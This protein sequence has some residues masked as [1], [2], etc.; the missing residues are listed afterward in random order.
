VSRRLALKLKR[1]FPKLQF[2]YKVTNEPKVS[3]K[4]TLRQ[5]LIKLHATREWIRSRLCE[6][7]N[8]ST[9]DTLFNSELA[10]GLAILNLE[11]VSYLTQAD[12]V[13]DRLYNQER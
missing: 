12:Y 7:A 8:R 5:Q 1:E 9:R 6:E 2:N 10:I 3:Q 11:K 13:T 4:E